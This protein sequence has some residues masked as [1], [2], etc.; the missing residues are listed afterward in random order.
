MSTTVAP[1]TDVKEAIAAIIAGYKAM[2]KDEWWLLEPGDPFYEEYEAF[3][4]LN[5]DGPELTNFVQYFNA[6]GTLISPGPAWSDVKPK[7]LSDDDLQHFRS[8]PN[9]LL[10]GR[11]GTIIVS[12]GHWG[13]RAKPGGGWEYLP[14][15][16]YNQWRAEQMV[17]HAEAHHDRPYWAERIHPWITHGSV[18]YIVE[19]GD[20]AF[21]Q[22][23]MDGALWEP[24]GEVN[25][26]FKTA[27]EL[28][29]L[30]AEALAFAD[31]IDKENDQ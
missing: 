8:T 16:A 31:L 21:K 24:R 27:D 5:G 17:Q 22:R 12:A 28:R 14:I 2:G 6:D 13:R 30:A 11:D 26:Y 4:A 29:A 20:I 15:A 9:R 10:L 25:A 7:R 18:E 1:S 23:L 3:D 19:R